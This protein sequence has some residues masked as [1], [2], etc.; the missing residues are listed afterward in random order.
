MYV[1]PTIIGVAIRNTVYEDVP[2]A[3]SV[4]I[5]KAPYLKNLCVE[6]ESLANAMRQLRDKRGAIYTSYRMALSFSTIQKGAS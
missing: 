3:L 5:Q 4:A 2:D 1:G 6:I